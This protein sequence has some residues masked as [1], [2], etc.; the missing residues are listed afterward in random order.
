MT[1]PSHMPMYII[2]N[3]LRPPRGVGEAHFH[4]AGRPYV[5]AIPSQIACRYAYNTFPYICDGNA[6]MKQCLQGR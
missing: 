1:L 3:Q 6:L 5:I 2:Q 4:L